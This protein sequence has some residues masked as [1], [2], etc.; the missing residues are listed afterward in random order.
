MSNHHNLS[1]FEFVHITKTGG[2]SIEEWGQKNNILWGFK[3]HWHFNR[4]LKTFD[5]NQKWH[6]PPQ[7]FIDNPYQNKKTFT[8]VRNPY[9]RMISEYYCPWSGSKK[10]EN[11]DK[12]EFNEWIQNLLKNGET[13]NGTPQ[14]LYLPVDY[15]IK[16]ESLQDDFTSLIKKIIP[17]SDINTLLPHSNKSRETKT[18]TKFTENDFFDETIIEIN[19]KYADDFTM[20][21]YKIKKIDY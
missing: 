21:N 16:F 17:N 10:L 18:K 7:Y 8:C 1:N 11:N 15:V 3:K 13:I 20:F 4:K 2:T 12:V 9:T 6:A 19:K 5:F 14:H